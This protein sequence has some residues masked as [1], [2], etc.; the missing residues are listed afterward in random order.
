MLNFWNSLSSRRLKLNFVVKIDSRF[1]EDKQ[2]PCKAAVE[3]EENEASLIFDLTLD[4]ISL[5]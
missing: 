3:K 4:V 2:K 1:E 5:L